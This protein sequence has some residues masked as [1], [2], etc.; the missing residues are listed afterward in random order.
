MNSDWDKGFNTAFWIGM[1]GIIVLAIAGC[2]ITTIQVNDAWSEG[3]CSANGGVVITNEV[4]NV[5]DR[6]VTIPERP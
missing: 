6:L 1:T 5:N 4:C 2:I 3:W